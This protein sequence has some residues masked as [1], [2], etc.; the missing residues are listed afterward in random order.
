MDSTT[1]PERE[2]MPCGEVM[3][4]FF[5]GASDD[6]CE[7]AYKVYME[8]VSEIINIK[9]IKSFFISQLL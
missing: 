2:D 1:F 8:T 9:N 6:F 3:P 7:K 5:I 4:G